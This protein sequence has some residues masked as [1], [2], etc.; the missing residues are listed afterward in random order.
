M[1][2][3]KAALHMQIDH[4][5]NVSDKCAIRSVR[6]SC[7][8]Q[9][10]AN[11]Q[12][13]THSSIWLLQS[14]I[15]HAILLIVRFIWFIYLIGVSGSFSRIFHIY[16]SGQHY[17]GGGTRHCPRETKG[18]SDVFPVLRGISV[19][20]PRHLKHSQ[21]AVCLSRSSTSN[22]KQTRCCAR[23][24]TFILLQRWNFFSH[25]FLSSISRS[26]WT[27]LVNILI[28]ADQLSERTGNYRSFHMIQSI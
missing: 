25:C 13:Y 12:C 17:S 20:P 11:I 16:N 9:M 2:P 27:M 1:Q 23:S 18:F 22:S 19:L 4:H 28:T 8:F 7:T 3:N 14:I 15:S 21:P 5:R 26:V 24:K 10:S 6:Q